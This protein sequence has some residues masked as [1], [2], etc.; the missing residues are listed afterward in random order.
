MQLFTPGIRYLYEDSTTKSK[1][2][3][4]KIILSTKFDRSISTR[5]AIEELFKNLSVTEMILDFS[6]IDFISSSAS[7]QLNLEIA[8]LSKN[9]ICVDLENLNENVKR[10]LELT[11]K[12]RSNIFTVSSFKHSVI[13]NSRDL[14]QLLF[15]V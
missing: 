7:H 1:M 15:S 6:D 8:R 3:T 14:D 9:G 2:A 10:M 4:L 13:R 5:S 12:D 11:K